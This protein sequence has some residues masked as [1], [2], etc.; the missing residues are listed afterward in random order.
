MDDFGHTPVV[1]NFGSR[2]DIIRAI[3][4]KLEPLAQKL[5]ALEVRLFCHG[6]QPIRAPHVVRDNDNQKRGFTMKRIELRNLLGIFLLTLALVGCGSSGGESEETGELTISLTDA[7]GDFNQYTIDVDS[8]KLFKSNGAVIETLPNATRLD[9]SRYV[10]VTEFLSTA[11]VPVGSYDKAEISLDYSNAAITVE[12]ENGNSIPALAQDESGNPLGRVTLEVVVNASSGFIIRP[13]Q[14]A[15][16]ILDFD[17]EASNEVV[18]NGGRATV[19]VSPIL[20]AN[21]SLEDEKTRRLRGLLTG[22]SLERESFN[23]RI[24][25]FRVRHRDFGRIT[26][27]TDDSTVFEIDGIAYAQKDGLEALSRLTGL[28]PVV[29]L[30][31]FIYTERRFLAHQVLAGS[32]VPWGEKDV[33]KGSVIARVGN[34]LTVVGATVEFD[35]GSFS[36]NDTI[37]VELDSTTRITKQGDPGNHHDIDDISVGQKITALGHLN[38]SGTSLNAQGELVRMRYSH[39]SG[40]VTSVSPFEVELQHLNRRMVARY[41]FGGTGATPGEDA[42][43][44]QYQIDNGPLGLATLNP[45]EP[46]RVKGFPTPFGSAPLD[47]TAKTIIDLSELPSK[48]LMSYGADG[49]NSAVVSLDQNGLLLDLVSASGRHHLR[50]AGVI[51]DISSL[52]SV[53]LIEPRAGQGLYAI[54][55]GRRVHVYLGWDAWQAALNARLAN[56]SKLVFAIARGRYDAISLKLTASQLVVRLTE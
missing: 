36:F 50:Q 23:I 8:I 3:R 25:P 55:Q 30:G 15:A 24:R 43:P 14:P 44:E 49:S 5:G 35:D 46:V 39:V 28:T 31:T 11:T 7:E 48:M 2:R 38:V 19:T 4:M 20:I 34:R 22:V 42:D 37:E 21:T 54:S 6:C 1:P 29:A 47:F 27:S 18:I 33:V 41:E 45:A 51:T 10:E 56:G 52:P 53:P 17:L 16:L 26:A 13:G 40:L 32:S 12:D 9:F